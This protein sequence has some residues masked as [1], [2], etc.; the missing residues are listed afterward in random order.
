MHSRDPGLVCHPPGFNE[1]WLPTNAHAVPCGPQWVYEI[2]IASLPSQG[3]RVRGI[4]ITA[5]ERQPL[6][7]RAPAPRSPQPTTRHLLSAK[8]DDRLPHAL[9]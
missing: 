8:G 6:S 3:D 5:T 4:A 9:S 2:K 7:K 1:P